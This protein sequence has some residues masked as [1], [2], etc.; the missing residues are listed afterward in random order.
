MCGFTSVLSATPFTAHDLE[1]F[2]YQSG[3]IAH[4]GPDSQ[5]QVILT[6]YCSFFV[7]LAIRDLSQRSDQPIYSNCG[8]YIISFNGEIYSTRIKGFDLEHFASD[9]LALAHLVSAYGP[10]I[11]SELVG[12]FSIAI[13]HK[14]TNTL[15][16]ARDPLGLKPLFYHFDPNSRN[17]YLSSEQ[18]PL[19][20]YLKRASLNLDAAH[21][22]LSTGISFSSEETFYEAISL[23]SPGHIYSININTFNL[24]RSVLDTHLS[25]LDCSQSKPFNLIEHR[26]LLEDT[27]QKHLYATASLPIA[28]TISSGVDSSSIAYFLSEAKPNLHT[29]FTIHSDKFPTEISP[30]ILPS[31]SNI[32][33]KDIGLTDHFTLSSLFKINQ[34]LSSPIRTSGWHYMTQLFRIISETYNHK[35]LLVGEGADELYSGY[36]SLIAPF[37]HAQLHLCDSAQVASVLAEYELLYPHLN[38]SN[39]YS[40]YLNTSSTT[41]FRDSQYWHVLNS[42]NCNE[43]SI[44]FHISPSKIDSYSSPDCFYKANLLRYYQ[45]AHIP[46]NVVTLDHISMAYGL[47]LR[48]PFLDIDLISS[49]LQYSFTEHFSSGFNK[50][51]LRRS[52]PCLPEV[53]RWR[54]TKL[55]RPQSD[56]DFVYGEGATYLL[57]NLSKPNPYLNPQAKVL[58]ESHLS[59]KDRSASSFWFRVLSFLVFADSH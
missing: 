55:Q 51:H 22:F 31:L 54:K 45:N 59:T 47:E 11:I 24:T 20:S 10:S 57:D 40:N 3:L 29:A 46:S 4:R 43:D 21:L 52:S 53:F 19:L 49:F 16:F 48:L 27:F 6:N 17:I 56:L 50:F 28:S 44:R 35:I 58:F 34:S 30:E 8:E 32:N 33:F 7:R 15:Y 25:K 1:S 36:G 9:T 18:L 14:K 39:Q 13:F 12:M 42:I 26:N 41:D 5:S 2:H 38:P 37:L 23:A